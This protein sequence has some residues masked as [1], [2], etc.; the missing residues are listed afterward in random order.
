MP[1][2][3]Q[4]PAE[5]DVLHDALA[6]E[7]RQIVLTYLIEAETTVDVSDL[8]TSVAASASKTAET[9][10]STEAI[11]RVTTGL[12]HM[13]LPKLDDAGFIQYDAAR[14]TV[15]LSEDIGPIDQFLETRP[16]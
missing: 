2:L 9:A 15:S 7:H 1:E 14:K 4:S 5:I 12:L 3:E 16:K 13:H 8:A 6:H 11:R 10:A